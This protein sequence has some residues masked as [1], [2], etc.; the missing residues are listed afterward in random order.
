MP[1]RAETIRFKMQIVRASWN[2][3]ELYL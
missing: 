2:F 3:H 1:S